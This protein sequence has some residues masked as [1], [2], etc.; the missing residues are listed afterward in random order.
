M[1]A[2]IPF[3]TYYH[4]V[5]YSLLT[6]SRSG[7]EGWSGRCPSAAR[8]SATNVTMIGVSSSSCLAQLNHITSPST[9]PTSFYPQLTSPCPTTLC[10]ISLH[11][12]LTH[13][14]DI[15]N[16]ISLVPSLHAAAVYG[17]LF[18]QDRPSPSIA[19]RD[20]TRTV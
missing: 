19:A 11:P 2:L 1:P 14:A 6:A 13:M 8:R 10:C 7:A 17:L 20:A 15:K 12:P 9:P 5:V 4:H 3:L 18:Q 16:Q